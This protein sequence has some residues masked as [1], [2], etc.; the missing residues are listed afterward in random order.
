MQEETL[1]F[2][3]FLKARMAKNNALKAET[4]GSALADLLDKAARKNLFMGIDDPAAWQR[5]IRQ[6]H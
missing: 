1:D 2:I 3:Q 4:N 6:G 5:E